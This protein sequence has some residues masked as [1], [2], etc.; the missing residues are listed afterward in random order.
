MPL[1]INGKTAVHRDSGGTVT[2]TS[3][4]F[5]GEARIPTPYTNIARTCD[6][7]NTAK[8]VFVNGSPICHQKSFFSRSYGDELGDY[9]GIYSGT[10]SGRAEFITASHDVFVEGCAAVRNQDLMVSNHRNTNAAPL[11]QADVAV[12]K[13]QFNTTETAPRDETT[14]YFSSWQINGGNNQ[15]MTACIVTAENYQQII[16]KSRR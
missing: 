13:P 14:T 4:N 9:G 2:T 10:V 3:I 8:R 16:E 7:S 1:L 6:A 12:K 5:T 15:D 11:Q